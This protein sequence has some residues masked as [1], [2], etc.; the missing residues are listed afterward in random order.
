L[1]LFAVRTIEGN[2]LHINASSDT[3]VVSGAEMRQRDIYASNGVL[4]TV[5]DLLLPPGSLQI[6]AEKYL[7]AL[8]CSRFIELL[9]SVNLTSLVTDPDAEYTILAPRDDVLEISGGGSFP[10]D[11]TDEL[12]KSLTYHFIP[13]KWKPEKL[14]DGMLLETELI[15]AGLSG[16]RQVLD[17]GVSYKG[18]MLRG[19]GDPRKELYFA[20]AGVIGDASKPL[21]FILTHG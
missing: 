6:N 14:K 20:G 7:L 21:L 8:N 1:N 3:I 12:K 9:R 5:S 18:N 11:G 13:G 4:H 19:K 15:E 17:V 2:K 10:K 16:G